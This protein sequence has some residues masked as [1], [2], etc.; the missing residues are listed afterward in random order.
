MATSVVSEAVSGAW[1]RFLTQRSTGQFQQSTMWAEV[2]QSLGWRVEAVQ[3]HEGESLVGG[4]TMFWRRTWLGRIGYVTKGPVLVEETDAAARFAAA[5]LVATA[6]RLGLVGLVVQ[7]PDDSPTL[8]AAL[9]HHRFA[10]DHWARVV[11]ATIVLEM[12]RGLDRIR[13]GFTKSLRR[14]LRQ[15]GRKGTRIRLGTEEDLPL[16][17]RLMTAT[18][19]RRQTRPNPA[20]VGEVRTIWRAFEASRAVR[21]AFAYCGEEPVA[22]TLAIGFGARADLWKTGWTGT[23]PEWHSNELLTAAE[24]EWAIEGRRRLCDFGA[25]ERQTARRLL[26]GADPGAMLIDGRYTFL[27]QFGGQPKLLPRAHFYSPWSLVRW[28]HRF[29]HRARGQSQEWNSDRS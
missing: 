28:L 26:A 4:F 5:S 13:S 1:D 14:N 20:S 16:F 17:H 19:V 21:L 11:D 25:I 22:A 12:D 27:L 8:G 24:L 3:F 15:A 7:P 10:E 23:H 29:A 9:R 18:C 2:K 6:R